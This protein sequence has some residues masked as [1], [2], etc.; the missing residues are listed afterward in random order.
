[1]RPARWL[2]RQS[3][4]CAAD[5]PLGVARRAVAGIDAC[6]FREIARDL[7]ITSRAT[8]RLAACDTGRLATMA[9]RSARNTAKHTPTR[10]PAVSTHGRHAT[11]ELL[12][13]ARDYLQSNGAVVGAKV[14]FHDHGRRRRRFS[15]RTY[16]GMQFIDVVKSLESRTKSLVG[17]HDQTMLRKASGF[18]R[19]RLGVAVAYQH[20]DCRHRVAHVVFGD[21]DAEFIVDQHHQLEAGVDERV[22]GQRAERRLGRQ[23]ERVPGLR[24]AQAGLCNRSLPLGSLARSVA[25]ERAKRIGVDVHPDHGQSHLCVEHRRHCAKFAVPCG[26]RRDA[27]AVRVHLSLGY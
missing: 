20:A 21:H 23:P 1:M 4:N 13:G 5:S 14:A 9:T 16:R 18:E 10:C 17:S 6:R 7:G 8:R 3:P 22:A 25:E 2:Q 26:E 15:A 24:H 11:R 27:T 12:R 19:H